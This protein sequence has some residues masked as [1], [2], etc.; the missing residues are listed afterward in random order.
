MLGEYEKQLVTDTDCL[1]V[2]R[3][4]R[5]ADCEILGR[6]PTRS[7]S[8]EVSVELLG[9]IAVSVRVFE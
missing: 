3:L 4:A 1:I 8:L 5:V 6:E 2:A 9:E 7:L